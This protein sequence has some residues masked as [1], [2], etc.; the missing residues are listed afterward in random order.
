[1][2]KQFY[3]AKE[4]AEILRIDLKTLYKSLHRGGIKALRVGRCWRIPASELEVESSDCEQEKVD[5]PDVLDDIE[6]GDLD[7]LDEIELDFLDEYKDL[8][9]V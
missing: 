2:G 1:M 7:F 5:I 9:E 6:P 4:A 3:T 8:D